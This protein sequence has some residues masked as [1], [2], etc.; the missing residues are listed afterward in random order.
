MGLAKFGIS[1]TPGASTVSVNDR[2]VEG[3]YGLSLTHEVGCVPT[4]TL[5]MSSEGELHGEG[6][7]RVAANG[8]TDATEVLLGWLGNLDGGALEREVLSGMDGLGSGESTGDAFL[9]VLMRWAGGDA[10][11]P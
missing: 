11:R 2:P 4:L 6:I 10:E 5:F 1:V 8:A 9:R 3:A 7:V